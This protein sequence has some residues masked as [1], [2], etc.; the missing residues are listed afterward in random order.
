MQARF[1]NLFLKLGSKDVPV[2]TPFIPCHLY[3]LAKQKEDL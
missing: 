2:E 1:S 3:L